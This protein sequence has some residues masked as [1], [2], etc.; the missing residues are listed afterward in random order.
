M[1]K[2]TVPTMEQL[3]AEVSAIKRLF[4]FALLRSGASQNEVAAALGVGQ[5]T[6]SKM[7]PTKIGSASR[8]SAAKKR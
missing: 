8:K 5:S 6:I 3:S 4:V 7:F 2:S 1:K